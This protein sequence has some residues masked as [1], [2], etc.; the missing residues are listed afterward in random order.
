MLHV[1]RFQ[2]VLLNIR[3]NDYEEN[4]ARKMILASASLPLI[5][6]STEVL[7]DKY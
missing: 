2:S 1:L 3:I 5:Y 4:E 6:D 7:G